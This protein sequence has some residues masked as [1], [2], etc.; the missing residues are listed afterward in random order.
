MAVNGCEAMPDREALVHPE[1]A[2]DREPRVWSQP[3]GG[4]EQQKAKTPRAKS[5]ARRVEGRRAARKA[6]TGWRQR[7]PWT[8]ER[9][10]NAGPVRQAD[11]PRAS[12]APRS[13]RAADGRSRERPLLAAGARHEV[14]LHPEH[15]PAR[16][17]GQHD[18]AR[19]TVEE[20]ARR[21]ARAVTGG[22]RPA[23]RCSTASEGRRPEPGGRSS[24]RLH[25]WCRTAMAVLARPARARGRRR[26]GRRPRATTTASERSPRR[27]PRAR[28]AARATRA[29]SAPSS[30]PR[31]RRR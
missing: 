24:A 20:Q 25:R 12:D 11:Q 10:E 3:R 16:A 4:G 17:R 21:S 30:A 27:R 28:R 6:R 13:R 8:C 7:W 15:R 26:P 9:E 5:D 1:G 18:P 23:E 31:R 14:W 2:V 22:E 29:S 19:G